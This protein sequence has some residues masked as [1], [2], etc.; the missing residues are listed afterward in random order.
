[1]N[2]VLRVGVIGANW[3]LNHVGA[4]RAVPGV[5]VTALCTSRR[6]TAEAAARESGV[7]RA[8]WNASPATMADFALR[9]MAST[10][11]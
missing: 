4:W 10:R 5:E 2:A 3:G 8:V 6:G 9:E 1:L 11:G 7:A